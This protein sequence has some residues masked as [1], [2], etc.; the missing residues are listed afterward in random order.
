MYIMFYQCKTDILFDLD[1]GVEHDSVEVEVLLNL[2]L[3]R[4]VL[5][6]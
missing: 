4:L 5:L 2:L 1:H 3:D 6:G